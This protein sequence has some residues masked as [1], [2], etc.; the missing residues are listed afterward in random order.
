MKKVCTVL[1]LFAANQALALPFGTQTLRKW[2]PKSLERAL[3]CTDF[4]GTWVGACSD[5]K[6]SY[7]DAL[8]IAQEG[9]YYANLI[10]DDFGTT[11]ITFNGT[12]TTDSQAGSERQS[13]LMHTRWSPDRTR[14]ITY[15]SGLLTSP[16]AV[17]VITATGSQEMYLSD[18]QLHID[19]KSDMNMIAG[20]VEQK[21]KFSSSC[22]YNRQ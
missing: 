18:D 12:E 4:S 3:P 7:E 9:C 8:T 5:G 16:S 11:K 21:E 6:E 19:A 2:A 22:V 20:G 1:M 17:D 15:M 10:Y 14:A 13:V